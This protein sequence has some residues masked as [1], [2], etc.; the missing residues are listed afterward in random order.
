ML[1]FRKRLI[2]RFGPLPEQ[3]DELLSVVRL[4]WL[5]CRLGIE[6]ILLKQ[7]RMTLYL[8]Q[9]KDAY[10]QSQAF[11]RII[12][13]A[14]TRPKRCSLHEEIDKHGHKT[15][16]RYVYITNVKTVAGAINLL[17]KVENG[18]LDKTEN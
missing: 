18:D 7:E 5:C 1:D 17:T 15:G 12:Q 3:A 10:W 13:Y 11:G 4:R 16:R 8:V 9:N 14:V 6:K 2:D